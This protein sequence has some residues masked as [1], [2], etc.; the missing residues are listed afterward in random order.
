MD[1]WGARQSTPIPGPSP[2]PVSHPHA[3]RR[4]WLAAPLRG[5]WVICIPAKLY[6]GSMKILLNIFSNDNT[7]Q[8]ECFLQL[9]YGGAG[10]AFKN[11]AV[12]QD[13]T[14]ALLNVKHL[15]DWGS[16]MRACFPKPD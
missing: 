16:G 7:L 9:R 14:K 11:G 3:Q 6:G 13:F 1:T 12:R 10:V 5:W 4:C 8:D 15:I 2:P